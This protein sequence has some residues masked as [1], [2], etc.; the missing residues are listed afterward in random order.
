M[1]PSGTFMGGNIAARKVN[2]VGGA[3]VRLIG[4]MAAGLLSV[5]ACS[6]MTTE[7]PTACTWTVGIMGAL[8]GDFAHF[9]KP[10]ARSVELAVELANERGEL[11]C[12][13]EVHKEDTQ[14]D[15]KQARAAAERLVADEDLVACMCGFFSGETFATGETFEAGG[16]AMLSTGEM[17]LIRNEGFGT[18]FRLVAPVD[19]QGT[20]TGVYIRRVLEPRRV[21][22]V[23]DGQEYSLEIAR[24]V[25][26]ELRSRFDGPM[27]HL[28]SEELGPELAADDVR[29]KSPDPDAVFYAGYAEQAWSLRRSLEIRGIRVPFV[30]DGGAMEASEARRSEAGK[31]YLTCACTD[32]TRS[33]DDEA[34]AFVDAYRER[35]GR[36]P[37]LFAPDAFDGTQIVLEALEKLTGSETIDKVRAHVASFLDDYGPA[38]GIAKTYSWDDKG[39][40]ETTTRD[41]WVWEWRRQ[42]GFGLL[43]SVGA[44]TR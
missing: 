12:T 9:A 26:E 22:V 44:L 7:P 5:L 36:K 11:A 43:G 28:T 21:A 31:G 37:S 6:P 16:V 27:I 8:S 38:A 20:A 2:N 24:A 18:W 29:R 34:Q 30:T 42:R 33:E 14:G 17:S 19:E 35:F 4:A 40:L 15:P 13:L 3:K 32:V 25:I 39:E 10:A 41:V 1:N 23:H